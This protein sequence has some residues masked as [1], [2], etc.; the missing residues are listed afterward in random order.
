[1]R[2]LTIG[3]TYTKG[4]KKATIIKVDVTQRATFIHT[5]KGVYGKK[6]FEKIYGTK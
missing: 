3:E 2:R 1:M 4:K 6:S 5:N